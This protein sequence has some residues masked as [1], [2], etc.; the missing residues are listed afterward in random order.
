MPTIRDGNDSDRWDSGGPTRR[1]WWWNTT[2]GNTVIGTAIPIQVF[3]RMYYV[4]VL[5]IRCMRQVQPRFTGRWWLHLRWYDELD[6]DT[7]VPKL[8]LS[9]IYS[10]VRYATTKNVQ[11]YYGGRI[12]IYKLRKSLHTPSQQW[13]SWP[14]RLSMR[15][16]DG[17]TSPRSS[18]IGYC[19]SNWTGIAAF[20]RETF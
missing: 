10:C 2:I 9:Y 4:V 3:R 7:V 16:L 12:F 6:V 13:T 15:L 11:S 20:H 8:Y 5:I 18:F 14:T 19:G 1:F 17:V